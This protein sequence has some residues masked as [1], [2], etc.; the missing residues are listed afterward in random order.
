MGKT[1]FATLAVGFLWLFSG[2]TAMTQSLARSIIGSAGSSA[3]GSNLQLAFSVGEVAIIP[4]ESPSITLT[5][6]FHQR[7]RIIT[8]IDEVPISVSLRVYPNPF[9]ETLEISMKGAVLSFH[10]ALYDA[11]G[12]SLEGFGRKVETYG[13]WQESID[14]T[15]HPP[16]IYTL[17]ITNLRGTWA[18]TY[19]VVKQ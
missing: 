7:E 19:K 17:L 16:G 13:S 10:I 9:N 14:L 6:G 12:H 11:V 2:N 4:L 15:R 18:K 3:E 1:V 5:Q 8:G